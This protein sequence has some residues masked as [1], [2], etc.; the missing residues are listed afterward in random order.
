M[1]PP[2]H[3]GLFRRI[4]ALLQRDAHSSENDEVRSVVR[5][6][7]H[8]ACEYCL[9]P[10]IGTFNIEHIIPPD[11]WDDYVN[12]RLP[13]VPFRVGRGGPH[14]IENYAWSCPYCNRRKGQTVSLGIGKKAT[15][16]FDP[17]HDHWPDHF[18][19]LDGSIYIYIVGVS[20]EGAATERALGFNA[21]GIE[22]PLGARHVAI[23][24]RRYPPLWARRAYEL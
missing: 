9:L 8:D 14:H 20:A 2:L 17:R 18:V 24:E 1:P 16:I 7:A 10:T 12:G 21:G 6:R 19:F 23:R 13:G 11:R 3:A 5:L 22:G 4:S 15:R